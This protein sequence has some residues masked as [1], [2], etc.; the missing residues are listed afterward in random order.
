MMFQ[1]K[2][3]LLCQQERAFSINPAVLMAHNVNSCQMFH[4][5]NITAHTTIFL[6]YTET[7]TPQFKERLFI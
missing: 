6:R 7:T 1:G 2:Y 3:I 5:E 4:F